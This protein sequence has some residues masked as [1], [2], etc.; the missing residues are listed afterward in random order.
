MFSLLPVA[1]MLAARVSCWLLSVT[2]EGPGLPE[3]Q[4]E[5]VFGRFV[6]YAGP[7]AASAGGAEPGAEGHG[8]GLAICRSI[9]QLHGGSIR[10]ENRRDGRSGLRVTVW[11]PA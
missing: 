6:R 8:L 2:D 11:L 10:A 9:A 1:M 4:L 7:D 5:K 3:E